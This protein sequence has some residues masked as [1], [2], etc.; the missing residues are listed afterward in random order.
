M[1]RLISIAL[2]LKGEDVSSSQRKS[3]EDDEAMDSSDSANSQSRSA[4]LEKRM[5][6]INYIG[7]LMT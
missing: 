4:L 7:S 3:Q 6:A 1:S 5:K 2:P